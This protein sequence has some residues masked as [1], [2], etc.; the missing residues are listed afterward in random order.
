MSDTPGSRE[1]PLRA[2]LDTGERRLAVLLEQSQRLMAE[3]DPEAL[4]RHV[5]SAAREI[6]EARIAGVGIVGHGGRLD[7]LVSVGLDDEL[8]EGLIQ[9]LTTAGDQ[10]THRVVANRE[11]VSGTRPHSFLFVPI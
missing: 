4:L 8:A 9:Q 3:R 5:A 1:E 10:P 11:V 2:L 7:D 6:T